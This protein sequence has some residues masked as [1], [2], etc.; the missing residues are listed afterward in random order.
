MCVG[1]RNFSS[2]TAWRNNPMLFRILYC[3]GNFTYNG[4]VLLF[5]FFVRSEPS[6][7]QS[8]G[9]NRNAAK[10]P[11]ASKEKRDKNIIHRIVYPIF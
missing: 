9:R 2:M 7:G 8:S 1:V 6:A 10:I 11:L 5:S 3:R 4:A